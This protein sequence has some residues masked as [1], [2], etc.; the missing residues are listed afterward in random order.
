MIALL[1]QKVF[2]VWVKV[3]KYLKLDTGLSPWHQG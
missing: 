3:G 1:E 2:D